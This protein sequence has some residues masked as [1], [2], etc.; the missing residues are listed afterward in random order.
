MDAYSFGEQGC[1]V[2]VVPQ[3]RR[4]AFGY[5]PSLT[6][7]SLTSNL[8]AF[9]CFNQAHYLVP[10]L[11]EVASGDITT[12]ESWLRDFEGWSRQTGS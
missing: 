2:R 7:F 10:F 4:S 6:F 11:T 8:E 5:F 12:F 3:W 1:Q 9:H